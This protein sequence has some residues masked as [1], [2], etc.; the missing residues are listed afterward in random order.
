MITT[1]M[2]IEKAIAIKPS[3]VEILSEEEIDYCTCGHSKLRKILE[4]MNIDVDSFI[5]LLKRIN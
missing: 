3:I 5:D 2:S 4:D 1:E